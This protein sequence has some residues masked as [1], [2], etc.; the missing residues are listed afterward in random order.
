ME[1]TK[2]SGDITTPNVIT[3]RKDEKHRDLRIDR[4]SHPVLGEEGWK[5][6]WTDGQMYKRKVRQWGAVR[7]TS[8]QEAEAP[9]GVVGGGSERKGI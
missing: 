9:S 5:Q 8:R 6:D 1:T 7:E 4:G 3:D 2:P